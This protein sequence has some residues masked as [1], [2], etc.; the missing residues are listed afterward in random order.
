VGFKRIETDNREILASFDSQD[1][2]LK[3]KIEDDEWGR[4]YIYPNGLVRYENGDVIKNLYIN[5]L[6]TPNFGFVRGSDRPLVFKYGLGVMKITD[7]FS[8][9]EYT[10]TFT[11]QRTEIREETV[12]LYNGMLH[13]IAKNGMCPFSLFRSGRSVGIEDDY[14]F[15]STTA[16]APYVIPDVDFNEEWVPVEPGGPEPPPPEPPTHIKLSAIISNGVLQ[17]YANGSPVFLGE[18]DVP[19]DVTGAATMISKNA[20]P[21]GAELT[22]SAT[23]NSGYKNITWTLNGT[24]QT[25]INDTIFRTVAGIDDITLIAVFKPI[26]YSISASTISVFTPVRLPDV[27]SEV[28]YATIVNDGDGDVYLYSPTS[29]NFIVNIESSL[30]RVGA[31]VQVMIRP[32]ESLLSGV[33]GEDIVITCS[34]GVSTTIYASIRVDEAF[35]AKFDF[36]GSTSIVFD[37]VRLP[38]YIT[39]AA[40]TITVKNSGNVLV[41]FKSISVSTSNF[42]I[43][44]VSVD[45]YDEID[46]N[47]TFTFTIIPKSDL[48]NANH[49]GVITVTGIDPAE[50]IEFDRSI[51]VSF[52]VNPAW[53]FNMGIGNQNNTTQPVTTHAFAPVN[54]DYSQIPSQSFYIF[55]IGTGNITL[56]SPVSSGGESS[57]FEVGPLNNLTSTPSQM[58]NQRPSF[59]V[60]PKTGLV[61]GAYT[62]TVTVNGEGTH[63]DGTKVTVSASFNVTFTVNALT[64]G[65]SVSP[66]TVNFGSIVQGSSVPTAVTV[67][68]SN[69][70]S[71]SIELTQLSSPSGY[72]ISGNITGSNAA[73]R[74]LP[75]GGNTSFTI[76]PTSATM[77]SA[78]GSKNVTVQITTV[79]GLS[80]SLPVNLSITAIPTRTV[81]WTTSPINGSIT[82]KVDNVAIS[83]GASVQQGKVVVFTATPNTGYNFGSWTGLPSDATGTGNER[84][85]TIG[86]S[87]ISGISAT[88]NIKTYDIT[89]NQPSNGSITAKSGAAGSET[90]LTITNNKITV[91]H[92]TRVVFTANPNGGYRLSSWSSPVGSV[93]GNTQTI[94]SVTSAAT[95]ACTMEAVPVRTVSWTVEG[96]GVR[97]LDNS[98]GAEIWG[99]SWSGSIP[100]EEGRTIKIIA[101]QTDPKYLSASEAVPSWDG[102]FGNGLTNNDT[103]WV[104]YVGSGNIS[105]SVQF[106]HR[107][108]REYVGNFVVTET[109]TVT[110]M[111][112][113]VTVA[114]AG[115]TVW[116]IAV[117]VTSETSTTCRVD[118]GALNMNG[119]ALPATAVPGVSINSNGD[120]QRAEYTIGSLSV[121]VSASGKS[122]TLNQIKVTILSGSYV[123]NGTLYLK[124]SLKPRCAMGGLVGTI[125]PT[126]KMDYTGH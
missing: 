58:A 48:A 32:K 109:S 33:F 87:N 44:D 124:M 55:N 49:I 61:S 70:G 119:I 122:G 84:S 23:A 53:T 42:I 66:S 9:V 18:G 88:F 92:G 72:T 38:N 2:V 35:E 6:Q 79:S 82:A 34:N 40:K 10:Y 96:G 19:T 90:N 12:K 52:L 95:I 117:N 14:N 41:K 59:T 93:S 30:L 29:T 77:S 71:G 110:V 73:N 111:K 68:V 69:T 123:R 3:D 31:S 43:S 24:T 16:M 83:S 81:S 1:M 76:V 85:V 64:F 28:R 21:V 51:S 74:T 120:L 67:T 75:G 118:M 104:V 126:V 20:I 17:V 5:P 112:N 47:D 4:C 11:D 100:I 94:S 46:I 54:V 108:F 116:D 102:W 27:S 22:F 80:V 115:D 57:N 39:P 26:R 65:I 121:P 98:T 50:N 8:S 36:V 60:R 107:T 62:E 91:N 86:S 97:I 89:I 15:T 99:T 7:M 106:K 125:E 101:V 63:T 37:P 13:V 114:T 56:T 45:E 113:T 78:V 103:E 105:F 25:G